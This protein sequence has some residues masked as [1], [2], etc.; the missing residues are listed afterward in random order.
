MTTGARGCPFN[1]AGASRS[2]PSRPMT[3]DVV[4][5]L[6]VGLVRFEDEHGA[7]QARRQLPPVVQVRVIHERAGTRRRETDDERRAGL[8]ERRHA[9]P[10]AAEAVHAVVVAVELHAVPVNGRRFRQSIHQRDLDRLAALQNERRPGN[11]HACAGG[12][13]PSPAA[14]TRTPGRRRTVRAPTAS[15]ASS[16]AVGVGP[17]AAYSR[18]SSSMPTHRH[19]EDHPGHAG[20]GIVRIVVRRPSTPGGASRRRSG[21]TCCRMWQW[22]SQLPVARR[23]PAHRHRRARWHELRHDARLAAGGIV[24][25]AQRRRPGWPRRSRTRAGASCAPGSTG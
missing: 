14:R 10:R 2:G 1:T 7:V 19:A 15:R 22:N 5:R 20:R 12:R 6:V 24:F 3:N 21:E 4:G 9:E 16:C 8:D 13:L 23:H 11:R 17:A 18:L 25:V